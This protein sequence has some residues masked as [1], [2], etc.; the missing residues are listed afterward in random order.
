MAND[1]VI[2]SRAKCRKLASAALA[3]NTLEEA[4]EIIEIAANKLPRFTIRF[5]RKL[6]RKRRYCCAWRR[7]L[8]KLSRGLRDGKVPFSIFTQKNA[9]LP[10]F[11][12][13][14]LPEFT[15]PGAGACLK[16]CYSF[17][18]WRNAGPFA[19]QLQN[20][21]LLRFRRSAI[22][23]AWRELPRG[24]VVR[25]Y[26]DGDIDSMS[27]LAFWVSMLSRRQDIRAYGYSKSFEVLAEWQDQGLDWPVNYKLNLSSGSKYDDDHAIMAKIEGLPIARGW[28]VMVETGRHAKGFAR[29]DSKAYH[30]D[31]RQ[32]ARQA[33]GEPRVFSCPGR[34]GECLPNGEHA[35]GADSMRGVLIAIGEHN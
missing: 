8:I 30:A 5:D 35:C 29:F 31:V 17:T 26:T 10:F 9:K 3:A 16:V 15:C 7:D 11:S 18:G 32:Q 27:T 13:S 6:G 22:A 34:C 12:F 25:L 24:I 14:A 28:F 19:R 2:F 33:Y 23:S 21:L 4:C 20:T 1:K